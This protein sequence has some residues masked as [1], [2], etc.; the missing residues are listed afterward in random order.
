MD[1]EYADGAAPRGRGR[2]RGYRGADR[3]ADRGA[4][5]VRA[6]RPA[7]GEPEGEDSDTLIFCGNLPWG[8]TENDLGD[9]FKEY[10]VTGSVVSRLR[11][12]RSKGFGFVQLGSREKQQQ[13]LSDLK[14][15]TVD[16]RELTIKVA[17]KIQEQALASDKP[18]EAIA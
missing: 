11:S 14:N 18:E 7:K 17:K 10:D 12:G 6:P 16:G 1:A 13:V 2:G 4:P 15:I 9:M 3:G 8:L 5:R